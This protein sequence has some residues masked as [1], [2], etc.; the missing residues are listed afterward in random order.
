MFA[1]KSYQVAALEALEGFF[2]RVRSVGLAAAWTEKVPE[3]TQRPGYDA[4]ALGEVPAV[5]VRIPTGGGKTL[6][7][8][9]AVGRIGKPLCGNDAPVALWLVPSDAIRAQTLAALQSP[10]HPCREALAGQFGERTAGLRAGRTGDGQSA[11]VE[12]HRGGRDDPDLQRQGQ[13]HPQ[14]LCGG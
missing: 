10:R 13:D 9:H 6:L 3:G 11:R 5:C 2:E 4:T 14:C 1:L 7:A 12:R 8:A